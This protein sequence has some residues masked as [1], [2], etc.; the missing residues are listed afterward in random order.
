MEENKDYRV[1]RYGDDLK[2]G[3]ELKVEH[4]PCRS[5]LSA[6]GQ[7]KRPSRSQQSR[8]SRQNRDCRGRTNEGV[9]GAFYASKALFQ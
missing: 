1:Y 2:P 9:L 5:G 8:K 7:R 6:C 4:I 3:Y